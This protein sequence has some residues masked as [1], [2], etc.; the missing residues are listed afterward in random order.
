L[1]RHLVVINRKLRDGCGP[2][3]ERARH[4]RGGRG[5]TRRSP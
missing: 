5:A 4:R 1:Q 3:V 2:D